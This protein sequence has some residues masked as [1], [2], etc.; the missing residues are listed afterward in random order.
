M[1][2]HLMR[3]DLEQNMIEPGLMQTQ[4]LP[5]RY[6]TSRANSYN[7]TRVYINGINGRE[8]FNPHPEIDPVMYRF[9]SDTNVKR[10]Q[11]E[12]EKRN[13]GRPAPWSLRYYMDLALQFDRGQ[14]NVT[15]VPNYQALL[16]EFIETLNKRVM[17]IIQPYIVANKFGYQ[18]YLRDINQMRNIPEYPEYAQAKNRDAPVVHPYYYSLE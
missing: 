8:Q 10:I 16:D 6:C 4:T 13:W 5:L 15:C 18:Q 12:C 3:Q 9:Y 11:D 17:A 14:F 7:P 2:W 1:D